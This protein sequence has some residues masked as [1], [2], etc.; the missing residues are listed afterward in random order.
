[1]LATTVSTTLT[2]AGPGRL[3]NQALPTSASTTG[4]TASRKL[5]QTLV[6]VRVRARVKGQGQPN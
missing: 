1:M 5:H 3:A 6:T 4:R 2:R